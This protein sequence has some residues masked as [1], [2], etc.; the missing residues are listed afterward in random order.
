M[1]QMK[2]FEMTGHDFACS[3]MGAL[4]GAGVDGLEE[5]AIKE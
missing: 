2:A 3:R 5:A 1:V 4:G